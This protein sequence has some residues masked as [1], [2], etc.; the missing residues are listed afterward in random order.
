MRNV[1]IP[2]KYAATNAPRNSDKTGMVRINGIA[3]MHLEA[4]VKSATTSAIR[5]CI[6]SN[7]IVIKAPVKREKRI[8]SETSLLLFGC[9]IIVSILSPYGPYG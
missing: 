6:T 8:K 3:L 9:N 7:M 2:R 1:N 5:P 4:S